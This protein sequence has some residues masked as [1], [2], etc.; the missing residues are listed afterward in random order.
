MTGDEQ[1]AG[2]GIGGFLDE[3]STVSRSLDLMRRHPTSILPG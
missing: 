2:T 3:D 1:T